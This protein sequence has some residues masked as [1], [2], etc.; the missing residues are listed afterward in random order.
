[1]PTDSEASS[2]RYPETLR[3]SASGAI[4]GL[5]GDQLTRPRL[6]R[7]A[8]TIDRQS[9]AD[10][11][12]LQ[13]WLEGRGLAAYDPQQDPDHRKEAD[14]SR[15]SKVHGA[16]FDRAFLKVMLARHRTALRMAAAEVRDGTIPE[17]R[18]LARRMMTELQAQLE[19]MAA[20]LRA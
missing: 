15:L 5:A 14:L 3:A 17:L 6:A 10:L 12:R 13:G 2:T 7:L 18:A 9:Q 8:G 1:M 16:G 19:Q 4:V 11:Q 20:L